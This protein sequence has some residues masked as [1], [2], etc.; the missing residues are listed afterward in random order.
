MSFLTFFMR[1][2]I[3]F[4]YYGTYFFAFFML[5]VGIFIILFC[6]C[7]YFFDRKGKDIYFQKSIIRWGKLA[8]SLY[9][10]HFGVI[11][12]GIIVFPLIID[13]IYSSG[14]L[15]YQFIIFLVIFFIS[16]EL[17]IRIWQK[18]NFFLGVE[19][20]MNKISKKTLFLKEDSKRL[21]VVKHPQENI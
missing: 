3:H 15:I 2:L 18:Y 8:F 4:Y 10:I 13:E 7:Y 21:N 1:I 9:Y 5:M 19:W 20:F 11:A 6:L 14:F 16:L 12:I 17:F